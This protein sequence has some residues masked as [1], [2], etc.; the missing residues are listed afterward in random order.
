MTPISRSELVLGKW[1]GRLAL[2]LV[3]VLV[4]L[5]FG[6]VIFGMDWVPDL[7]RRVGPRP[8]GGHKAR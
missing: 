1:A 5:V 6:T 8:Q 3:Q 7:P 4:A 2:A